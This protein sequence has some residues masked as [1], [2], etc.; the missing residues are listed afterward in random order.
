MLWFLHVPHT[1]G[2]ALGHF[3]WKEELAH[4]RIHNAQD[5]QAAKLADGISATDE[6]VVVKYFIL[7]DPV[8]RAYR[9]FLHYSR[10]LTS[11]GRVNHLTL[12]EFPPSFNPADPEQYFALGLRS[13]LQLLVFLLNIVFFSTGKCFWLSFLLV[14]AAN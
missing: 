4:R 5:I 12:S 11:I 13:Y 2:R 9:E 8:E 14:S 3:L 10:N 1:G 7:R 6:Q